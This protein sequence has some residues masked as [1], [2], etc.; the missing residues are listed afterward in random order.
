MNHITGRRVIVTGGAGF[1]GRFVCEAVRRRQPESLV[2]PRS[3]NC[4]LRDRADI[5]SL[6]TAVRPHTVI[7]LAAVVGGIGANRV[8]PGKYFYD[9][10]IMGIQLLE[11][12]RLF[13]VEKYV[14][15][16]TICSY[17][18][19]T[20]VPF[21]EDDLWSGYPEETNAP[22][23]LAKKM[24]L[25]Q[26]QA[27]RQQYGTNA[28]TLLPVNLY[29]PH[30]NF[31][32]ETSHVIPALIRKMVEARLAGRSSVEAWGTGSASR[33]FLFVR[34]AA[35]AIGTVTDGGLGDVARALA[36]AETAAMAQAR[37]STAERASMLA[38]VADEI[39]RSSARLGALLVLESGATL[40][41]A[42]DEVRSA[43][44]LCRLYAYQ[45]HTD[46]RL[47]AARPLGVVVNLT[48]ASSPLAT[49][50]GQVAA[51]LAAGNVVVAK[52]STDASLITFE[53]VRAFHRAGLGE[54]VL[55][56]VPGEGGTVGQALVSDARVGAV[57]FAGTAKAARSIAAELANRA[58]PPK[59]L[60]AVA[61]VNAMIVDSSALPEQ[62][63]SDALLSAFKGAGQAASSLRLLCLQ[64]S[65]ADKVLA[66]LKGMLS[67]RRTGSPLNAASDIGPVAT[68]QVRERMEAYVEHMGRKGFSVTRGKLSDVDEKANFVAPTIVDLGEADSLASLDA[69]VT[70]PILHVVRF[71][72]GQMAAL[73]AQ[74]GAMGCAVQG[75]HTRI[76][77]A[78]GR[79]LS[80]TKANSVCINRAM[81]GAFVGMQPFGGVGACG[82]G[83]MW[84]GPLTLFALTRDVA[85]SFNV[86]SGPFASGP[87]AVSEKFYEFP[88]ETAD[89]KL[90]DRRKS[91]D[92][93]RV[94]NRSN[95]ETLLA[96]ADEW[97]ADDNQRAVLAGLTQRLLER[98][99]GLKPITLPALS[100]EENTVEVLPRGQ[101]LCAGLSAAAVVV[102]AIN[103]CAFG[104]Q[105][106]LL[107]SSIAEAIARTLGDACRVVDS[108]D[109]VRVIGGEFANVRPDVVIVS[110]NEKEIAA[111]RAMAAQYMVGCVREGEDGQY[112]WTQLVRERVVTVN[113]SAAGGNTQL[114]VLSEDAL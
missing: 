11:Q 41:E 51:S 53:A 87:G 85:P 2:V 24:L 99:D 45:L 38:S 62:V 49:F 8:N 73:L 30:D 83:P 31:D 111:I 46:G 81:Q 104:N 91:M 17:P 19:H 13:A 66:M 102:Q 68:R 74:L 35:E 64:D 48:P 90:V 4:D 71:K 39:E 94:K 37:T 7:H 109:A 77:E 65:T 27:Y 112:D 114:M 52:P 15:V 44:N 76:N 106:V 63:I 95:V 93:T 113:A 33:E 100:G 6:F 34:D 97:L 21:R 56:Y 54:S 25:V 57:V 18:K 59:F 108:T 82:T 58:E 61:S 86:A 42:A 110:R 92:D 84:G 10:A 47:D 80:N 69:T 79:L 3:G 40:A 9:N 70:G 103:A 36:T 16:G 20:P 55:Q 5:E 43:I 78:T 14:A 75:L 60:S 50:V 107:R 1:L 12:A 96:R 32:P 72:T 26:A 98:A 89:G 105:V 28:V 101:V 67:E 22:Y 88:I 29:G 23:G